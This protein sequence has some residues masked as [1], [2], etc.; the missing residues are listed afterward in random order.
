[1]NDG[2]AIRIQG[3]RACLWHALFSFK[4]AASHLK[5]GPRGPFSK[6][7]CVHTHTPVIMS[8]YY[9][10]VVTNSA[11]VYVGVCDYL[12]CAHAPAPDGAASVGF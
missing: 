11:C 12:H 3:I 4:M 1:M 8:D 7:V 5:Q 6:G 2:K 10:V 9:V